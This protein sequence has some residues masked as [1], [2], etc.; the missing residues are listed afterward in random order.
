VIDRVFK[1]VFFIELPGQCAWIGGYAQPDLTAR[2]PREAPGQ[3]EFFRYLRQNNA[4]E[5]KHLG[6]Y[7]SAS[8]PEQSCEGRATAAFM[9]AR[10]Q[11]HSVR[12]GYVDASGDFRLAM[13]MPSAHAPL[14]L[15]ARQ[16]LQDRMLT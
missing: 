15:I 9:R 6:R 14:H 7:L 16:P 11:Q 10:G 2:D 12:V 5:V 3:V 1:R 4:W 8:V 13:F